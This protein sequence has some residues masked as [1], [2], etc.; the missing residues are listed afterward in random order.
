M[1]LIAFFATDDTVHQGALLDDSQLVDFDHPAAELPARTH[2]HCWLDTEG[3]H[4]AAALELWIRTR[5]DSALRET[6][7]QQGAVRPWDEVCQAAPVPR[8]GKFFCIGLNYRD[9][10]EESGMDVP[11]RPLIFSKFSSCV[12]GPEANVVLPPTSTEVDYEAEFGIVVGRR[13]SGVSEAD[14]LDYVLGYVCIND[15]SARDFQFADGQ[16]QR[17]KACDTFAPMGPF[18]RTADEVPS[19]EELYIPLPPEWQD[20][21][22]LLHEPAHLRRPCA[23]R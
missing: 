7:R 15:I 11:T 18:V 21:A 1:K 4:H 2:P 3:P 13:A 5:E 9:H 20:A 6:L 16:W 19:P 17:G 22:R 14:A 12:V 8:P 10:A 23:D